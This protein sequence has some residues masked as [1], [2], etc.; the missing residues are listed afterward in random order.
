MKEFVSFHHLL[1]NIEINS[2]L[3]KNYKCFIYISYRR[4]FILIL[5]NKLI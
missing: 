4:E 2:L 3:Y 1:Y 5:Y